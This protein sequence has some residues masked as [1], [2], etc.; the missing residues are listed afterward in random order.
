MNIPPSDYAWR[1]THGKYPQ[2]D[3]ADD[4]TVDLR[5]VERWL[6]GEMTPHANT[7]K[8][9]EVQIARFERKVKAKM[10]R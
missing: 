8:R 7:V 6:S 4:L 9:I 10:P 2:S 5:T 3:L 1:K